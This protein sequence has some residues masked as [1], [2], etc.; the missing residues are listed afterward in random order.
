MSDIEELSTEER[1]AVVSK[2]ILQAPPG[3]INDVVSGELNLDPSSSSSRIAHSSRSAATDVRHLL[4]DDTLFQSLLPA[5]LKEY[6]HSQYTAVDVPGHDYQVRSS[7][8]LLRFLACS[9]L[10]PVFRALADH[11]RTSSSPSGRS[12]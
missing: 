5:A 9:D 3:E 6:N 2:Y 1:V 4:D 7:L 12:S 8:S 10:T 11:H